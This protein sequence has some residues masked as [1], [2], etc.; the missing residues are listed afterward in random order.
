M[1]ARTTSLPPRPIRRRSW[2]FGVV[3][4][5]LLTAALFPVYPGV[6]PLREGSIVARPIHAPRDLSYESEVRTNAV[7]KQAADAVPEVVV[8]DTA[9]RD[10]QLADL[11][12]VL[13]EVDRVRKDAALSDS[14]KESAIRAIPGTAISQASA[15]ALAKLTQERWEGLISVE[16]RAVLGRTLVGAVPAQEVDQA[17][18]RAAGFFSPSLTETELAAARELLSPLIITTLKVDVPRTEAQRKQA[19]ENTP[20]VVVTF[21]R[22]QPVLDAGDLVDAA[23]IEALDRL[24]INDGALRWP[25]AAAAVVAAVVAGVATALVAAGVPS[26]VGARR[27][28]LFALLLAAAV[29]A[30]KSA[31]P[32]LLPDDERRFLFLALPLCAAPV[33]VA[34]FL[35]AGAGLLLTALLGALT[36]FASV[37]APGA[38]L[39][40]ARAL[41]VAQFAA[42]ITVGS[43]VAIGVVARSDRGPR[44]ILAGLAAGAGSG[45][46]AGALLLLDPDRR[47]EDVLW[48]VGGSVA[49]GLWTAVIAALAFALLGK[50]FGIVTRVQLMELGQLSHPLLRRLQDEAPGTFQHAMLVGN[51]AERAADRIGADA[52]LVRVGAYYHDVGKLYSPAFFVENFGDDPS[53]HDRIDPMQS[54]RVIQQ[55]VTQGIELARKEKLPEAVVRFIPEHH[56]TR[57]VSYFYRRAAEARPDISPDAFRY[58]GPRPQSRETALVMIADACEATVRSM[59]DRSTE[60]IREVVE[61]TIRERIEE[62]QFDECPISLRDLKVVAET[63]TATLNAV[64]H[65]RVEYPEPTRRELAARGAVPARPEAPRADLPQDVIVADL[66]VPAR[67]AISEDDTH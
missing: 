39:G 48:L 10:R 11:E 1:A 21:T 45:V 38:T 14:A 7:R 35:D 55:H 2:W 52:L 20:P 37:A 24:G 31:A 29:F 19:R 6:R 34:L 8:L 28:L 60:R 67:R 44:I 41:E 32:F 57:L 4:A 26:L 63:Y 5:L 22:G 9:V 17:K 40:E 49:G 33:S 12:R 25:V 46:A 65:P 50:M 23:A 61:R 53:P 47:S 66:P 15:A 16:L 62:G 56:G 3:V 54:N 64:L 43:L 58:P 36:I 27:R 42:A 13:R 18:T 51:L 30:A 59:S